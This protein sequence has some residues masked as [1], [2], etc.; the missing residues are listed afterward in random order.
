QK[1]LIAFQTGARRKGCLSSD[2][3]FAEINNPDILIKAVKSAE[4]ENGIIIRV[5]ESS[6]RVQKNAVISLFEEAE[7]VTEVLANEEFFAKAKFKNNKI[8][9]SINPFGV[10]TFKVILKKAD[11]KGKENFKKLNLEYNA[12]GFTFNEDKRNV[13]LQGGGCSLPAELYPNSVTA[14]GITF[15]MS[16]PKAAKDVLVAREQNIEIPK[17]STKLYMLAASTLGD[18][19]VMFYLDGKE[20]PITVHSFTEPIGR[21]DMVALNQKAEIK[22]VYLGLEFTHT[23]HPEGDIA[24][25]KAHFFIYE[26]DV[27]NGKILTLP[28]DNRIVIL[29]MTAVKKFSNTVP[30]TQITDESPNSNYN[31]NEIPPIDKI[32][33]KAD[34]IT[35]R[36]GKIQ[37]Q[38]NSGKGKGFKRDN[39][40]TNIIRSYTKSE[41]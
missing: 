4:D 2:F 27:R 34:F 13:I 22:E 18:R 30:A 41:W 26:I 10:K 11:K 33:D 37:E 12:K 20:R 5:Q 31:F 21:W 1:P 8:T 6:G 25:G 36:A 29:A 32:I 38:K 16:D 15:K 39:I 24:N 40:I 14:A 28:E 23:H 35:I 19:N 9:F 17:G 3:S 7:N